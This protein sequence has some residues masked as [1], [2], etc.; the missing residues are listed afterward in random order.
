MNFSDC[1]ILYDAKYF[2]KKLKYIE[3]MVQSKKSGPVYYVI[4]LC[5]HMY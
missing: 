3:T 2:Q 4:R 1:R 5:R